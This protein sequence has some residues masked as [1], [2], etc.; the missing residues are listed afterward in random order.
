ML[1]SVRN[2]LI[3][4]VSAGIFIGFGS[5]AYIA[6]ESKI[7]GAL[8]LAAAFALV[9][10]MNMK[11]FTGRVGALTYSF[12]K[13][14]LAGT[15]LCLFGN[16]V[17]AFLSG[18]LIRYIR[19]DLAEVCGAMCEGKAQQS[20]LQI[21]FS[22]LL[23]GMLIYSAFDIYRSEKSILGLFFCV[24]MFMLCGFEHSVA[25][26]F[27]FFLAGRKIPATLLFALIAVLGNASG[28]IL[29]ALLKRFCKGEE[30]CK[31]QE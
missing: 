8:L 15:A 1:K 5:A 20:Y 24:P 29:T 9:A 4:S 7:A 23:C 17:G 6:C 31:K 19:P 26:M 25:D 16:G 30:K 12:S 10:A 28:E 11:L 27:W 2:T 13:T 18:L 3:S 21:F 14:R 22:G